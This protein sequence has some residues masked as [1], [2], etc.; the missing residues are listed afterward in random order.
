MIESGHDPRSSRRKE[1][2]SFG[3]NSQSLPLRCARVLGAPASL[4]T[5]SGI[6]QRAGRGAGAPSLLILCGEG[7]SWGLTSAVTFLR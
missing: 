5:M 1:A 4:P 3:R 2:H 6:T 7:G